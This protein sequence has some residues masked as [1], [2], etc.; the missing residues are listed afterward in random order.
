MI[1]RH[2]VSLG[3]KK[4]RGLAECVKKE[5]ERCSKIDAGGSAR[6]IKVRRERYFECAVERLGAH[7]GTHKFLNLPYPCFTALPC[8]SQTK[9]YPY[10]AH[11]LEKNGKG[12]IKKNGTI[13]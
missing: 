1:L 3:E 11:N 10:F 4:K 7:L 2:G 5:E 13:F 8:P 6:K 9:Q 12:K